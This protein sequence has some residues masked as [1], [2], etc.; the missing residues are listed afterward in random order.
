MVRLTLIA[1][2]ATA[3]AAAASSDGAP[4]TTAGRSSTF[5]VLPNAFYTPETKLAGGAIAGWLFQDRP[6]APPSNSCRKM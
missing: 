3:V 1:L 2:L 5:F 6:G 4:D